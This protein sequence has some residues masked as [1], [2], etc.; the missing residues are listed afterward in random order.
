[1]TITNNTYAP[2]NIADISA[3]H[4]ANNIAIDALISPIANSPNWNFSTASAA[5]ANTLYYT[6]DISSGTDATYS[7]I[8]SAPSAFNSSQKAAVQS[9]LNYTAGITG[10]KFVETATGSAANI[11]FA[12]ADVADPNNIGLAGTEYTTPSSE[13]HYTNTGNI[14]IFNSGSAY[15]YLDNAQFGAITAAAPIGSNVYQLLLHEIGHALGLKHP[16]EGEKTLPASADNTNNTL[17]SYNFVG[18]DK[19]TY[20]ADDLLALQWL[21]G[22]HG[23]AMSNP[24][25]TVNNDFFMGRVGSDTLA[26]VAG[27][28]TLYSWEGNDV[29]DGGAG[30]DLLNAGEGA[31]TL[32][33]GAGADTLTGGAGSDSFDLT[34]ADATADTITDW[35]LGAD[36]L[37]GSLVAGGLL[38]VTIDNSATLAFNVAGHNVGAF[39]VLGGAA[40][41]SISTSSGNDTL[42][43]GA[44]NDTLLAGAGNDQLNGGAGNDRLDASLG[45]DT[46]TGGAGNDIYL[47]DNSGDIINETATLATEIDGVTSS[48]N[49]TL[50][51]NLENLALTSKA[52]QGT[53]NTLANT[54]TGNALANVLNGLEGNDKLF[55]VGGSD[56]INGGAGNDTIIGGVGKDTVSTGAGND[57]IVFAAGTADS[58]A[59]ANS[60]AGVDVYSDLSLNKNL[61]DKIDLTVSVA[62]IGGAVTGTVNQASFILDMNT[63]LTSTGQGFVKMAGGIDAA[64]VSVGAGSLNAHRYLAIDLN[65]SDS[66]TV[67]D[68]V[69]DITGST[70]TALTTTTFV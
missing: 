35:G 38:T 4:Y 10:I 12:N 54:L 6:F 67:S 43:G 40:A 55:G 17:M 39:N 32:T 59:T 16:F 23:L 14:A 61:A 33:G 48:V 13:L 60:V 63:L 19:T 24:Q 26:G 1:M 66:F 37:V 49:Y 47:I 34:G 15:V 65:A 29:L 56:A 70:V 41:D 28:D 5:L 52:L 64:L 58:V 31:D 45:A 27:N 42:T 36:S 2:L 20:Q 69:I 9:I 18:I 3:V 7:G 21:Y 22:G 11:H 44:G 62:N 51:A 53:G 57:K 30:N 25:P 50:G 8:S 46:L 68:F